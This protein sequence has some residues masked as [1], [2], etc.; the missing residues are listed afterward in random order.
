MAGREMLELWH[1]ALTAAGQELAAGRAEG[2]H[3]LRRLAASVRASFQNDNLMLKIH[4]AARALEEAADDQLK[5]RLEVLVQLL[6]E[7]NSDKRPRQPILVVDDDAITRRILE[8]ALTS[9]GQRVVHAATATEAKRLLSGESFAL[10]ILDLVL[11]D[12]DG[13][14]ILMDIRR[15]PETAMTPV[16]IVSGNVGVLPKAECFALGADGYIEKPFDVAALTTE[17]CAALQ[18]HEARRRDAGRDPLTGLANRAVLLDMFQTLKV[19][20]QRESKPLSLVLIDMDGLKA[21]NDLH[22]HAKGDAAIKLLV[23]TLNQR[24]RGS[25]IRARWGGDEFVLLLPQSEPAQAGRLLEQFRVKLSESRVEGTDITVRFSAGVVNA[26][27]WP[28]LEEAVGAAD[29]LL[30]QAKQAGRDRIVVAQP[31]EA[32]PT[33]RRVL[34][35]EDDAVSAAIVRHRLN[36]AGLEV[37][38]APDGHVAWKHLSEQPFNLAVVDIQMPGLDGLGL[39]RK[40]RQDAG[41]KSLPVIMLT[42]LGSE[43]DISSAFDAGANDYVSK[44]FSPV[45]LV[46]RVQR[47]LR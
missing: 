5:P 3:S 29:K 23:S 38:H 27:N 46:K 6:A 21:I 28:T 16:F 37:V 42:A 24:L 22:G 11:P 25:D 4:E 41:L 30:Y 31:D 39:L 12:A 35:A 15:S 10:I 40:L 2:A 34:L 33:V 18:Q 13:R 36:A 26:M 19:Q 20:A 43:Q 8:K 17:L 14:T 32:K 1:K 47:L 45:E 44:P 7:E 9:S